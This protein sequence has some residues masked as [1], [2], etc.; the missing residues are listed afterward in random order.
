MEIRIQEVV[1]KKIVVLVK[2]CMNNSG[3]SPWGFIKLK[4]LFA[5]RYVSIQIT[6]FY[7]P[8]FFVDFN[9]FKSRCHVF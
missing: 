7:D 4:P 9:K 3:K 2:T 5:N 1:S 8:V 6:E